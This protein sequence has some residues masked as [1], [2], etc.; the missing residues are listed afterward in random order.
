MVSWPTVPL[1]KPFRA[2]RYDVEAAGPLDELVAPPY[3]VVTPEAHARLEARSPWNVVRL[4]RPSSPDEAASLLADWQERG[5][6]VREERPAVWLL[7]EEFTGP[8]E[9]PRTRRGIVARV[10]LHPYG[11]GVVLPHEGTF[12]EPKEARLRLLRATRTKLS[13]IFLLHHGSAP[14]P[15][16]EPEL[17]AELDGV[18]S[19][20][21]RLDAA[22]AI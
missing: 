13:P 21:W 9:V 6:L 15:D 20:L 2:L 14:A 4:V 12:A 7:E 5:V 17:Q 19:R 3:D 8:D 18:V 10:R 11:D 16:G 22:A 1:L